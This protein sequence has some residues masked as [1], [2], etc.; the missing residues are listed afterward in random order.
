[1]QHWEPSVW[2][3]QRWK[4]SNRLTHFKDCI[5]ASD[6]RQHNQC[7]CHHQHWETRDPNWSINHLFRQC[8]FSFAS[9]HSYSH[10]QMKAP[11]K[12]RWQGLQSNSTAQKQAL[13]TQG[14]SVRFWWGRWLPW[15]TSGWN[16]LYKLFKRPSLVF[17]GMCE[18]SKLPRYL[19]LFLFMFLHQT[20]SFFSN[21]SILI[22]RVKMWGIW[23]VI[24]K[25][26]FPPSPFTS[27]L[28]LMYFQYKSIC[29]F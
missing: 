14:F 13:F 15:V 9:L 28:W 1:M 22:A 29:C 25:L 11:I 4:F 23:D 7:E 20:F 17:T 18:A 8:L 21:F 19:A 3:R 2:L 27:P 5:L 12:K 26:Q 24:A 10:S 16:Q 6:H